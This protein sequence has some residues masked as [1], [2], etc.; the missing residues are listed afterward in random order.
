MA[1][2]EKPDIKE[3]I[4][5][6]QGKPGKPGTDEKHQVLFRRV[7]GGVAVFADTYQLGL[8][9]LRADQ[10]GQY[11]IRISGNGFQSR[12]EPV[13]LKVMT[14]DF[15]S[16]RN[17]GNYE[18]P[19]DEPRVVEVTTWMEEGEFLKIAPHDTNFNAEGKGNWGT[20]AA[21]YDGVGM[22]IQWVE[23]SGPLESWPPRSVAL[24][25]GEV[26]RKD[27]PE[28]QYPWRN[29]RHVAFELTPENPA[30]ALAAHLP[31]VVARAFRRPLEP[32]EADTAVR[33]A[34]QALTDGATFT[35]ALRTGWKAILTSPQFLMFDE[36]PGVLNGFALAN[37]LSYFLWSGPPDEE[38][39]TLAGGGALAAPETLRAQVRRMLKHER[40][41]Q[42]T[43]HFTGQWLG[44]RNIDAT[45]PDPTLYPEFD[46]V[47]KRCMVG[48]TEAFFAEMIHENRPVREFIQSDWL[49]LNRRLGRHYGIPG[50]TSEKYVRVAVPPG[51][52]RGGILTQ[53][54]VLKVTANGTTTSP[55]VRGTWV[56]KRL[57][58]QPPAPPPPVPAIEPD[59]RG[60]T[61]VREL[62]A[63]HRSSQTCN[64]CHRNIDPPGFALE[65]FDVI[66][67]WRERY[68]SIGE[69]DPVPGKLNG[70]S[71]WQY[72][73][74]LPVDSTGELPDGRTFTDIVAFKELLLAQSDTVLRA[75]TGHLLVY[76]TGAALDFADRR[77]VAE[78]AARTKEQGGGF[79]TLIEEVVLS[80]AFGRK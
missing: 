26:P 39:L 37:R 15:R 17:L 50:A 68:R 33:T 7:K 19:P 75:V 28:G 2:D 45:S 32:G 20:D 30:A 77:A 52:P 4:E 31:V 41:S 59:T 27:Y 80:V 76:G 38:L 23:L 1:L 61:T 56:M 10:A 24:A 35:E 13:T 29:N 43:T 69:G 3:N 51:S 64:A 9:T 65:S 74:G 79:R 54:A 6:P 67:G 40:A 62:L 53:A 71:I 60:A 25:A 44:L 49:M 12:G 11:T 47:L 63:K 16:M 78:I 34:Q 36:R 57:L 73:L 66:G 18:L 48:E 8:T 5:T 22:T 14:N 70:H 21:V 72:K 58:G 46:E 55:V 42:F